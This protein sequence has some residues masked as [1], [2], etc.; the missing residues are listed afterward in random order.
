MDGPRDY[1]TKWS[2]SD[3]ERQYIHIF[4]PG[5]EPVFPLS[6]ALQAYSLTC[7]AF[8]RRK[9]QPTPVLLPEKSHGQS[10]LVGYSSWDRTE[11]DMTKRLIQTHNIWKNVIKVYFK[12]IKSQPSVLSPLLSV[13]FYWGAWEQGPCEER[14]QG[15][16]AAVLLSRRGLVPGLLSDTKL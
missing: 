8:W 9:W 4:Y 13:N 11:L 6:P 1:H 16:I 2:K 7:W 3:R 12:W 5:I 10:S 14:G 15:Y